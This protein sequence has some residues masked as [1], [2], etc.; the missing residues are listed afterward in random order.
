MTVT[1]RRAR[2]SA[3]GALLEADIA[4]PETAHGL[5]LF[6]HGAGSARYSPRNRYLAEGLQRAGLATVLADLLT[7]DE[8]RSDAVTAE[9]RFDVGLLATR[10]AALTDWLTSNEG[11]ADLAIGVFGASTGAAA[12]LVTAAVRP[13]AVRTVV[14]RGGLPNLAGEFLP[15]VRQ[16]VLLVIGDENPLVLELNR[17]AAERLGGETHVEIIPGATHL[18]AEPETLER[19]AGLAGDWFV[20]H[21]APAPWHRRRRPTG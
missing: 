12:A 1:N 5:V 20:E 6:A 2:I 14:S 10:V 15:W 7:A 9:L 19:M 18:L 3:P 11:T 21:L 8:A 17:E 13:T 16:P 4:L